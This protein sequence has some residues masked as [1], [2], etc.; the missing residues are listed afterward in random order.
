M[1]KKSILLIPATLLLASCGDET[2]Q[3]NNLSLVEGGWFAVSQEEST[4]NHRAFYKNKIYSH[5]LSG[6]YR[7]N[8]KELYGYQDTFL[9]NKLPKGN[10]YEVALIRESNNRLSGKINGR[11]FTLFGGFGD[12]VGQYSVTGDWYSGEAE[13]NRQR[14]NIDPFGNFSSDFIIDC[15]I[16]GNIKYKHKNIFDVTMKLSN[17]S[18]DNNNGT[19]KGIATYFNADKLVPVYSEVGF[20]TPTDHQLGFHII[21]HTNPDMNNVQIFGELVNTLEDIMFLHSY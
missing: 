11:K 12:N 17:C 13:N 5:I 19:V 20:G 1:L 7:D 9:D 3:V 6:E 10:D 18:I 15:E 21:S 14:L 16:D 4:Y 2:G 8:G